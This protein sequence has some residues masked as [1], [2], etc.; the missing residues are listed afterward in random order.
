MF[1]GDSGQGRR[2]G[3]T[4]IGDVLARG[5]LSGTRKPL[6]ILL[7]T[8]GSH[9]QELHPN[10]THQ[11]VRV[12]ALEIVRG[13]TAAWKAPALQPPGRPTPPLAK[14]VPR[15][16]TTKLPNLCALHRDDTTSNTFSFKLM[17]ET[18]PRRPVGPAF[19][20]GPRSRR[21]VS[22]MGP[23][24][25]VGPIGPVGPVGPVIRISPVGRMAPVWTTGPAVPVGRTTTRL[26][27]THAIYCRC[28]RKGL[29]V[30]IMDFPTRVSI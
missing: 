18:S 3:N 4:R 17:S 5:S 6:H 24:G 7:L 20:V 27:N 22:L 8:K 13:N 2:Q 30:Q 19:P 23:V 25:P 10:F 14:M 16:A 11:S 29:V 28:S 26:S 1:S 9:P 12:W 15:K 21:P